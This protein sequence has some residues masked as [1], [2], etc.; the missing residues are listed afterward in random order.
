MTEMGFEIRINGRF[1]AC[2]PPCPQDEIEAD[3]VQLEG[4]IGV[5]L[6]GLEA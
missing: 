6:K 5:L 1:Y 2:K 4:E 3:I